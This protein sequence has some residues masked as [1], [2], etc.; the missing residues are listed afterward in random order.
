MKLSRKW[1]PVILPI[2]IIMGFTGCKEE[3]KIR[4]LDFTVVSNECIPKELLEEIES[5]KEEE[6]QLTFQDQN[7]LYLCVGYGKK[8]T[9]GYS[10]CVKDFY[11]TESSIVLDTTLLGPKHD[12]KKKNSDNSYPYIVIKTEYIDAVV[13]FS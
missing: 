5:K 9:G 2:L 1:I 4:N 8:E 3:E 11:L 13:I 6:F 10:I 7:Y 12:D